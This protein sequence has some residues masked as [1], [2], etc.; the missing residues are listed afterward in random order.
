MTFNYKFQ[1]QLRSKVKTDLN[2]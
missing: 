1:G 2:S